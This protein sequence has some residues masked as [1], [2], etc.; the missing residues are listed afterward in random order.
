[1]LRFVTWCFIWSRCRTSKVSK[2]SWRFA[3]E[4]LLMKSLSRF[5]RRN[6]NV[7]GHRNQLFSKNNFLVSFAKSSSRFQNCLLPGIIMWIFSQFH[8]SHKSENVGWTGFEKA[9]FRNAA[10]TAAHF[11]VLE[12][13]QKYSLLFLTKLG[14]DFNCRIH[15]VIKMTIV[16]NF[17][18]ATIIYN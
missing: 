6:S 14:G 5:W 11:C 18:V 8:W 17:T 1:M 15:L 7:Q 2:L 12:L 13:Q 9:K 4:K 16:S 3:A 10:V